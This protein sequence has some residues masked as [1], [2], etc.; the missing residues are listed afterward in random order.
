MP[1][2]APTRH[3]ASARP[4]TLALVVGL[5][6]AVVAVALAAKFDAERAVPPIVTDIYDVRVPPPPPPPEPRTPPTQDTR[7]QI[8]AIRP[9]VVIPVPTPPVDQRLDDPP[10]SGPIAGRVIE[11]YLPPVVDP[12]PIRRT[13]AMLRTSA[14]DIRPPYPEAKRQSEEE[15]TLRLKLAID[16]RGRVVA[17]EPVGRVDPTFFEAARRH[18]LKSWRYAPATENGEAVATSLTVSLQFQLDG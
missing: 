16:A 5:H 4:G 15:A 7:S 1:A 11:P 3:R 9:T 13:K 17:V 6:V 14:A 12:P 10:P 8:D 18:I 2:Y